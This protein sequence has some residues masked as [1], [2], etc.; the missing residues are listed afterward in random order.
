MQLEK[1][2][3]EPV[4][5]VGMNGSGTTM[6]LDCL[7][8]HPELYGFRR[9]TKILPFYINNIDKFGT[10]SNERNFLALFNEFRK[11][12]IFR[13][14]NNG[15]PPPLPDDWQ[16]LPRDFASI[17]DYIFS[18]YAKK[19][20]KNRWCEK[21]P[22]YAQHILSLGTI[23]NGAK[24]IHIIRDGRNCAASF[25]RRWKYSPELTIYRW[26]NVIRE[27]RRQGELIGQRY[28]EVRYE[29]LTESPEDIMRTICQFL[30]IEFD[31]R[32][33]EVSRKRKFTGS[34]EAKIVK[35]ENKWKNILTK[36]QISNIEKIG[37][38]LLSDL[39]YPTNYPLSDNTP[40]K[41]LLKYLLYKDYLRMGIVTVIDE[42]RR[43]KDKKWDDI[44]AIIIR[45][46]KQ[47]LTSKY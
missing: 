29:T 13:Y 32:M 7:N 20:G 5:I 41:Y 19:E 45:A 47:R 16:R 3:S 21:T 38:K 22:M 10:L 28:M 39:G 42:I 18:F 2:T 40:N 14:T 25:Y 27:A 1:N 33:L 15:E 4:F 30:D 35:N 11:L 23:F 17:V 36:R 8:N 31:R 9:E 26:K 24:F 34:S 46:I 37:G 43:P 6:L 12:S 44:H